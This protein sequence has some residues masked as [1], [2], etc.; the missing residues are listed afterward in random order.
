[1]A[2]KLFGSIDFGK[3]SI[4]ALPGFIVFAALL[5]LV[6]AFTP[7][8]LTADI[9]A[10]KSAGHIVVCALIIIIGSSILGLM[11]DSVFHTI[12][13][14]FARCIWPKLADELQY[15]KD[16]IRAL[17]L[18]SEDEFKWVQNNGKKIGTDDIESHY[19]R[20]TEVGGSSAYAT[21]FLSAAVA[22]F[23]HWEYNV[24]IRTAIGVS[25]LIIVVAMILLFTS[26]ASLE[27]YELNKTAM[28]MD[29]IRRLNPH[30]QARRDKERK[31][32][33]S[34]KSLWSLLFLAPMVV[35]WLIGGFCPNPSTAAKDM[36]VISALENDT[37][38]I[39]SIN[40]TVNVTS[41]NIPR[42]ITAGKI[43]SLD[44]TMYHSGNLSLKDAGDNHVVDLVK[45]TKLPDAAP[46]WQ[47]TAALGDYIAAGNVYLNVQ[48]SFN[49][50][51][52][53]KLHDGNW[54][55]PVIVIVK[56]D[57]DKEYLLA[58]VQVIINT[59]E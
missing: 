22:L 5:L 24:H 31:W 37:V 23:L 45:M 17:G 53:S 41:P 58:Y 11:F 40:T 6:D 50:T 2:S 27:K 46:G 33:F 36:A 25:F 47:L 44:H 9:L 19:M 20:N 14:R 42:A 55:L 15:R 18:D 49:T 48:L 26:S 57:S 8:H 10:E 16:L 34:K 30:P 35:V 56:D 32:P 21:V 7:M 3:L 12:G 29:E 54:L 59:T 1:M 28:A 43:I 52:N 51:D 38:P 39:I 13:R 4:N